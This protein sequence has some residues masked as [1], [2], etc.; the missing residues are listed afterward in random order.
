MSDGIKQAGCAGACALHI[1]R[2]CTRLVHL[3]SFFWY[4]DHLRRGVHDGLLCR[5]CCRLQTGAMSATSGCTTSAARRPKPWWMPC[6][7]ATPAL[8]ASFLTCATTLVRLSWSQGG[9]L[10]DGAGS[11]KEAGGRSTGLDWDR[12][13]CGSMS[14]SGCLLGCHVFSRACTF[15]W[16]F[17]GGNGMCRTLAEP[18]LPNCCHGQGRRG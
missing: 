4:M 9:W 15:R 12:V 6:A 2:V 11:W 8:P 14:T 13:L 5:H 3:D 7:R 10:S 18:W 17:R 1:C 16:C